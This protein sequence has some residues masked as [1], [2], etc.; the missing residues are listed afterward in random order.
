VRIWQTIAA[1]VGLGLL[2]LVV[3][4]QYVLLLQASGPGP[5]G[6]HYGVLDYATALLF[7]VVSLPTAIAVLVLAAVLFAFRRASRH[8]D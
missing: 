3:S 8:P 2:A 5:P 4:A 6:P 7:A 1:V